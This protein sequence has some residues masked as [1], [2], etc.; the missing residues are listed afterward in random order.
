[1]SPGG[2]GTRQKEPLSLDLP[3][4]TCL[5]PN[6]YMGEKQTPLSSEPLYSWFCHSRL[7]YILVSTDGNEVSRKQTGKVRFEIVLSDF[8]VQLKFFTYTVFL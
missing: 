4:T 1:M 5:P 6:C 3:E 7:A 8:F 2:G